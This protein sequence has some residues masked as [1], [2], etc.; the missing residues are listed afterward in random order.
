[1]P[2]DILAEREGDTEP[3]EMVSNRVGKAVSA[4]RY[5]RALKVLQAVG[6]VGW[7]RRLMRRLWPAG[8]PSATR[9]EQA[10]NACGLLLPGRPVT[11]QKERRCGAVLTA[12]GKLPE[13]PLLSLF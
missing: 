10:S 3:Y 8:G 2:V 13:E 7:E 4:T 5:L 12:T 9:T 11:P 1:M 6:L